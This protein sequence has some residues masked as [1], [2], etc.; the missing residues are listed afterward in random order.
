[1]K[2]RILST[3]LLGAI[4]AVCYPGVRLLLG[5]SIDRTAT[6][7]F[8][9]GVMVTHFLWASRDAFLPVRRSDG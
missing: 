2:R 3:V 5:E 6:A 4:A 9:A 7:W 1:M 8:V